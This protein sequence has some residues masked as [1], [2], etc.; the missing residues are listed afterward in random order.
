M[1][2]LTPAVVAGLYQHLSDTYDSQ[3]TSKADAEEMQA[4]GWAL[5]LMGILDQDTFMQ[6]FAT[7]VFDNIYLPFTPGDFSK[8]GAQSQVILAVHEHE[9][10]VQYRRE[11]PLDF[12]GSY[13]AQQSARAHWEAEAYRSSVEMCWFMYGRAPD[14]DRIARKILNYGCGADEVAYIKTFLGMSM[15]P[16]ERGMIISD[17]VQTATQYLA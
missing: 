13:L 5:G 12:C 17:V 7:T 9:H 3:V 16:I 14:L 4:I 6:R 15:P 11:G 2:E 1:K 8:V 10:V